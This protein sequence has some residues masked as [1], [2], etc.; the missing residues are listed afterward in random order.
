MHSEP[1]GRKIRP[2]RRHD[3]LT[4]TEVADRLL[5]APVTVRLWASRGLLRSVSTPGG[6]RRFREADVEAFVAARQRLQPANRRP[7][8]RLLIIDDD[9]Q[10]ARYLANLVASRAPTVAVDIALAGFTAGI[11]CES[12]RPDVVTLDLQMPDM[13]GVAVCRLL[14]DMFG[15]RKP[16]IVA[17]SG[18][19][20]SENAERMRAAGA[21]VCLSKASSSEILLHELGLDAP[22]PAAPSPA[23][24]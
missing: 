17:L 15:G 3:F 13:D 6:H 7:P 4:P 1:K 14:R 18:F 12:M 23:A 22:A 11:K 21:D 5:V 24:V 2:S 16:R 9:A 20:S 8:S 10:Y 19:L